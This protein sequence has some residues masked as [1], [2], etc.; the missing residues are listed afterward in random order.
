MQAGLSQLC[1]G[2]RSIFVNIPGHQL[3]RDPKAL[4]ID[5]GG[6]ELEVLTSLPGLLYRVDLLCTRIS[7]QW[8]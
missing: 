5:G 3:N 4:P 8:T 7:G 6:V 2:Q 1:G